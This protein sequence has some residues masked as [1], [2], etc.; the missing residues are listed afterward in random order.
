ALGRQAAKMFS[1]IIIRQDRNLRGKTEDEIINLITKGIR[2]VKPD[3][4]ITSFK[5]EADAIDFAIKNVHKGMFLT[6][7]SDV[8]PD[9]L[10]TIMKLKEQE[11][12]GEIEL[13]VGNN[14]VM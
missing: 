9:A 12:L 4:K 14:A 8:V 11:D 7:C 2:E 6:I 10:D 3:M 5:K 13:G 1:E